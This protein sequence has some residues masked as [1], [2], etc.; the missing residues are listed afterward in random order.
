[1]FDFHSQRPR[2][3]GCI[4]AKVRESRDVVF[5]K[6]GVDDSNRLDKCNVEITK[7]KKERRQR[8]KAYSSKKEMANL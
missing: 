7:G 1:M 8:F 5:F 6:Q 3:Q 2:R 4:D